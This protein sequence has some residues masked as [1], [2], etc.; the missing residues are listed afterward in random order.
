VPGAHRLLVSVA[1]RS[2]GP[3]PPAL[4]WPFCLPGHFGRALRRPW[5]TG[6]C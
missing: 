3:R 6:S 4:G 5:W 2:P 1:R